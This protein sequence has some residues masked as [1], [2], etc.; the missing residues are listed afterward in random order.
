MFIKYS[1]IVTSLP[2]TLKVLLC[3]TL[4]LVLNI[5]PVLHL[6]GYTYKTLGHSSGLFEFKA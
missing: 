3:F 1:Q 6:K 5:S 4:T 2:N